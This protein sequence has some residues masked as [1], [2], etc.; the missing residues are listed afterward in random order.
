VAERSGGRVKFWIHFG[1]IGLFL[2]APILGVAKFS[3]LDDC[4]VGRGTI[5]FAELTRVSARISGRIDEVRCSEGQRVRA[6][7]VIMVLDS[8][9]R[10][11]ALTELLAQ[12]E[13]AREKRDR[14]AALRAHLQFR[15]HPREL[16]HEERAL[17]VLRCAERVAESRFKRHAP[18]ES[19]ISEQ[20]REKLRGEWQ[21][22]V[23]R[24]AVQEAEIERRKA[25]RRARLAELDQS[26]ELAS[27][28]LPIL[29][30]KRPLLERNLAD[31]EV[32]SPIDGCVLTPRPERLAG[33]RV[34]AGEA[35]L[36]IADPAR[37]QFAMT[38]DQRDVSRIRS[39]QEVVLNF[40]AFPYFGFRS[41]LGEV[42]EVC[43]GAENACF[44]VLV[45]IAHPEVEVASRK[46]VRLR[47]GLSGEG[48]VVIDRS[49]SLGE[50]LFRG[51][52]RRA[53]GR[54]T[55]E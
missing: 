24:R 53:P 26:V 30:A 17:D 29:D 9:E 13:M 40:D 8:H 38:L 15:Q 43:P 37:L 4:A 2:A 54:S 41:F 18:L 46:S 21:E 55:V 44:R 50:Y 52:R 11:A 3:R 48:H 32:R 5:E 12:M 47:P 16:A 35:I 49:I 23:G 51:L 1:V 7:E 27:R 22:A 33:K 39:G 36:E 45:R 20:D 28:E 14:F 31:T 25:V 19:D 6:G 34:E 10:R 42:L